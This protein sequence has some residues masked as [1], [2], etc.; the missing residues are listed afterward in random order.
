MRLA[1]TSGRFGSTLTCATRM[2]LYRTVLSSRYGSKQLPQDRHRRGET[3]PACPAPTF[4]DNGTKRGEES[5]SRSCSA[6]GAFVGEPSP[7][8]EFWLP[9]TAAG[10]R[11]CCTGHSEQL[12]APPSLG[13]LHST[14]AGTHPVSATSWP[15]HPNPPRPA[16]SRLGTPV[17]GRLFAIHFTNSQ[18]LR[19]IG[20]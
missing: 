11:P 2:L 3:C 15:L 14:S 1:A 17:P 10:R 19:S 9:A 20:Y 16:G 18:K 4:D 5:T 12:S 13:R 8:R 7:P 6:T